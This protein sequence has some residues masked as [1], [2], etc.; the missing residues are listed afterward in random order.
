MSSKAMKKIPFKNDFIFV[1]K[2]AYV[3]HV[4][5]KYFIEHLQKYQ[6]TNQY[7][8]IRDIINCFIN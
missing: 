3:S 7:L 5:S 1:I 2:H 4:F 8:K 6:I